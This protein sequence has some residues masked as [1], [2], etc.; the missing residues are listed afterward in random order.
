[1]LQQLAQLLQR[2]K[3]KLKQ[4]KAKIKIAQRSQKT[5]LLT[6]VE[7]S[8]MKNQ[9]GFTLIELMIVVAIIGILASVAIPQYQDYIARTDAQTSISSSTQ[10]LKAALSEYSATYGDLPASFAVLADRNVG[11]SYSRPDGSTYIP[12]DY[13]LVDKVASVNYVGVP[14][15]DSAAPEDAE[16]TITITFAH[17]NLNIGATTFVYAVRLNP[18]GVIQFLIDETNSGLNSKYLPKGTSL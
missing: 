11:V 13:A 15:G 9:Q 1:M 6:Q 17:T 5:N 12:A 16:G 8:T 18:A 3:C 10:S 14:S 4:A 2:T 7:R